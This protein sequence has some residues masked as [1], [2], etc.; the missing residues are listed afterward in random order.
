M[1]CYK[2]IFKYR[3]TPGEIS[4]FEDLDVI[5]IKITVRLNIFVLATLLQI[6]YHQ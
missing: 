4:F 5:A 3:K 1:I 2:E 6:L